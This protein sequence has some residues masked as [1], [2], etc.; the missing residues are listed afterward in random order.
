L[1]KSIPRDEASEFGILVTGAV[2]KDLFQKVLPISISFVLETVIGN[3]CGL[4][5]TT[6]AE[7]MLFILVGFGEYCET[8]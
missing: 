2:R 3:I 7:L 6:L 5:K 1:E 4:I 8:K